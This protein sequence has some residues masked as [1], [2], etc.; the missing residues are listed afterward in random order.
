MAMPERVAAPLTD[1]PRGLSERL[2]ALERKVA[3]LESSQPEDKLAMVVFSGDLDRVFAS[4]IIA[5]GA[6]A[7]GQRVD[8]FFTF[9]GLTAL[10]RQTTLAGK[11]F[12][13][14]LFSVMTPANSRRLPLSRMNYFGIGSRMLRGMMK[15]RN[16]ASL[17]DLMALARE[18]GVNVIACDMSQGVMGIGDDELLEGLEH[19]G[20]G[21]FLGSA[22]R[23]RAALFI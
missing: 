16:V 7:T 19:G 23:S 3:E 15:Q 5:T 17:E 13:Q 11:G 10:K 2:E 9:W 8:M 12:L 18:L 14:K 22:L 21:T 20:V 6:A 4:F 1:H